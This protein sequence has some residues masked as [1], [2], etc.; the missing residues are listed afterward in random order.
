MGRGLK[1]D[2]GMLEQSIRIL[3]VA[4]GYSC[5]NGHLPIRNL[6]GT[7]EQLDNTENTTLQMMIKD[8]D[9]TG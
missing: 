7:S 8:L 1:Y 5:L 2:Y 3:G 4:Y 6:E 9:L